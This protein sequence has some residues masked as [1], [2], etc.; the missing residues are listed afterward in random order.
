MQRR[1][2]K[3]HTPPRF[4]A[5]EKEEDTEEEED[6]EEEEEEEEEE[7]EDLMLFDPAECSNAWLAAA[8]MCRSCEEDDEDDMDKIPIPFIFQ[9]LLDSLPKMTSEELQLIE[10]CQEQLQLER[11]ETF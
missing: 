6:E 5:S 4:A 7:K 9:E 1:R 10:R 3:Q 2:R 8:G 11:E